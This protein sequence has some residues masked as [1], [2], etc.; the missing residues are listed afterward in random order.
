MFAYPAL[1]IRKRHPRLCTSP[2][3]LYST[4]TTFFLMWL[5]WRNAKSILWARMHQQTSTTALVYSV[6]LNVRYKQ[7]DTMNQAVVLLYLLIKFHDFCSRVLVAT[8]VVVTETTNIPVLQHNR[9]V[10]GFMG[11]KRCGDHYCFLS[12]PSHPILCANSTVH[13]CVF[14]FAREPRTNRSATFPFW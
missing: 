1:S 7:R 9:L 6:H 3:L 8:S 12:F 14:A 4:T 5:P 13:G 10:K 2:T 11:F